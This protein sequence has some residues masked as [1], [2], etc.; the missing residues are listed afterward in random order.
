MTDWHRLGVLAAAALAV[1]LAAP[2]SRAGR[3]R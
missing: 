2:Y 1:L 3:E